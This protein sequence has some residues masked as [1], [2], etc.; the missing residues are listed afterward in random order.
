MAG[1]HIQK[2]ETIYLQ[3]TTI[4]V[5]I[6]VSPTPWVVSFSLLFLFAMLFVHRR[7]RAP[8]SLNHGIARSHDSVQRFGL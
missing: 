2:L 1:L 4:L 8:S 7:E 5:S 3:P 6:Q